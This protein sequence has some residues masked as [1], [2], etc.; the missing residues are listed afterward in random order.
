MVLDAWMA[1]DL[2]RAVQ[3]L[4]GTGEAILV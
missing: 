1:Y 3:V 4:G 2:G